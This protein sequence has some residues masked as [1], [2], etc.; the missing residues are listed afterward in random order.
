MKKGWK[1]NLGNFRKKKR[2]KPFDR[3]I[4]TFS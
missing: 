2:V 3:L 1:C 4:E